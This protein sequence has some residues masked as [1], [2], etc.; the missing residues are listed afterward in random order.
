MNLLLQ[1]I[2]TSFINKRAV[3]TVPF[4]NEL[5]FGWYKTKFLTYTKQK[6]IR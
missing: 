5:Q 1:Q 4:N 2:L 6:V 3:I